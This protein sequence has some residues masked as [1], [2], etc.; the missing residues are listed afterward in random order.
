MK[1]TN[2]QNE[3]REQVWRRKL[4]EA[5][6]K[7]LGI[8]PDAPEELELESRLTEMLANTPDVAVP[9]NF[10]ARLMQAID[11]EES[12]S[13]RSRNSGWNWHV[14]VP[15]FAITAAVLLFAGLTV[16]H[17]EL[18]ANRSTLARNVAMVVGSQPMPSME[19]LKNFDAIQRMS[20]PR[21][22]EELL[23]LM[24]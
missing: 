7:A 18:A 16:R 10:T 23:A 15:R 11:L 20:Q 3:L 9:S 1:D 17:Y 2:H 12:R 13:T 24:Q 4:T 8:R 5:E 14:L 19:A 6:R 21:A 22:D